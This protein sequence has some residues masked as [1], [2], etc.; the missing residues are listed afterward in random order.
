MAPLPVPSGG[1]FRLMLAN[2]LGC[3]VPNG[4]TSF[5]SNASVSSRMASKQQKAQMAPPAAG[6]G[7]TPATVTPPPAAKAATASARDGSSGQENDHRG[8]VGQFGRSESEWGSGSGSDATGSTGAAGISGSDAGT[9]GSD[10]G[11]HDVPAAHGAQ[12]AA[13][14]DVAR[15]QVAAQPEAPADRDAAPVKQWTPV[16]GPV[17]GGAAAAAATIPGAAKQAEVPS[18]VQQVGIADAASQTGAVAQ[19]V[20]ELAGAPVQLLAVGMPTASALPSKGDSSQPVGKAAPRNA[21]DAGNAK[22]FDLAS[23]GDAKGGKG[24][25]AAS[26][27]GDGSLHGAQSNGQPMPHAQADSAQTVSVVAKAID[28]GASPAQTVPAH[29]VA[30]ETATAARTP[31]AGSLQRGDSAPSQLDGEEATA[32]SGINAA[33]LIQTMGETEMRVGMHSSEFGDISI[34]TSVTQQQML[35]QISLDHGDLSHAISA[36]IA[37]MQAKL[38]EESGLA[39]VIEVNHSGNQAGNQ[40]GN[41]SGASAFGDSGQSPQREQR[42]FV[43]SAGTESTAVL[44]EADVGVGPGPLVSGSNGY[45]LDIR[46]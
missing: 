38:G 8:C 33:K 37:S 11:A 6:N 31:D 22:S 35:A 19:A 1:A 30:H 13:A 9:I 27:A 43:R 29:A 14:R 10:A 4:A 39:T 3:V 45:R 42:G 28:G 12:S 18:A 36:H 23:A 44:A 41:Q 21:G 26:A 24:A 32:T 46:A 2:V 15:P 7:G 20:A 25:E 16:A 34:R 17:D 40:F 5:G